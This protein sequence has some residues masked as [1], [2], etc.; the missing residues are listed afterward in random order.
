MIICVIIIIMKRKKKNDEKTPEETVTVKPSAEPAAV[1]TIEH[2]EQLPETQ[3]QEQ[4]PET[5]ETGEPH[6]QEIAS[7]DLVPQFPPGEVG[8]KKNDSELEQSEGGQ[9]SEE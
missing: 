1:I 2:E 4:L 8:K 6:V 9:I 3:S 7:P 5:T